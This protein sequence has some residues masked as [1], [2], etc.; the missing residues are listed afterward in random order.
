MVLVKAFQFLI[1]TAAAFMFWSFILLCDMDVKIW[2]NVIHC[3]LCFTLVEFKVNES[4]LYCLENLPFYCSDWFYYRSWYS[5]TVHVSS[6]S[7]KAFSVQ[8]NFEIEHFI[9]TKKTLL[10]ATNNTCYYACFRETEHNVWDVICYKM[11]SG[12]NLLRDQQL[13]AQ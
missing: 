8:L 13:H 7:P 5:S 2:I 10:Y 3:K 9:N 1:A 6:K 4:T 12:N 11:N